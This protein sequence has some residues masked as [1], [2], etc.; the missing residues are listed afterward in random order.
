MN[1][2]LTQSQRVAKL[3]TPLGQ[4]VLVLERFDATEG[5]SELFEIHIDALSEKENLKFDQAIGNNCGIVLTTHDKKERKF[6]G[7]LTEAWWVGKTSEDYHRYRLILRPWLWL[8]GFRADCRIFLNKDVTEIIKD[9][10]DK[11]GFTDYE[12]RLQESYDKIEY[13]VQYRETDLAFVS[14]L[15]EQ[16]GIYFFFEASDSKHSLVLTDSRSKHKPIPELPNVPFYETEVQNRHKEQHLEAWMSERR[17][18]TGKIQ[19]NDYDYLKP[20]KKLLAPQECSENYAHSKLEVYD[21]P[22]KY[23]EEDKGKTF[24]QIRLDAEQSL[25]HRRLADGD[26]PCLYPGGLVTVQNHPTEDENKQYLIVRANHSFV[27]P[28]QYRSGPGAGD[29]EE[30]HGRYEFLP[31][32]TQ[33][34]ALPV[35]KAPRIYGIQTAKVVGKQGEDSEE[36]STDEHGRIW[37]QFYWD[38]EPQKSCP[39]RVAQVWAGKQWGGQFLPRI[40]MEVVVEFL[41]G[42]P[43][44]PLVT[45]CVYNGDYK[46]PYSLADNKTQSGVKSESTKNG[47]N[48]YNEFMFE[49]KKGSEFIRM[50]AEKDHKVRINHVET[51]S[52]GGESGAVARKTEIEKGDDELYVKDGNKKTEVKDDVT[53]TIKEGNQST[54]L[55]MGNQ[56]TTISMGNQDTTIKMGNQSTKVSMGSIEFEAMQSITLK[57]GQ[58]KITIDQMGITLEGMMIKT[59]AQIQASVHG[60][61]TQVNADAMLMLKGAITMIN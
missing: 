56:S 32:D 48:H 5:L 39:V 23:K 8:L 53:L 4:D 19:L 2:Q 10:F 30:Y 43:D 52:I 25:D 21:Y 47:S 42:D 11:A 37:V 20:P 15:M 55:D 9:V 17:F 36:I 54:T 58:S 61:M 14:R 13:C 50:H 51:W 40:G 3:T 44:R 29:Q 38:R 1:A 49:D 18:R 12:L 60:L 24:A 31:R 59:D 34:R 46:V 35:T 57:V 28:L 26:A 45:G 33:F 41:E 27:S 22:G 16:F 7:V 6:N